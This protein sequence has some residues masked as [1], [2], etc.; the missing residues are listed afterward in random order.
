[1]Y[2]LELGHRGV[3]RVALYTSPSSAEVR[4]DAPVVYICSP[5][6]RGSVS[7][8]FPTRSSRSGARRVLRRVEGSAL[9]SSPIAAR[10][11]VPGVRAEHRRSLLSRRGSEVQACLFFSFAVARFRVQKQ[12]ACRLGPEGEMAMGLSRWA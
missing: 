12:G 11:V 8:R 6:R 2:Q 1:M 3:A 7:A 4:G 9:S 5:C 10:V